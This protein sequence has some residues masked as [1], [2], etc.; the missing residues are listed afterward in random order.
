MEEPHQYKVQFLNSDHGAD[1]EPEWVP[2]HDLEYQPGEFSEDGKVPLCW[3][4]SW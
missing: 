3:R 2:F 1:G 4:G